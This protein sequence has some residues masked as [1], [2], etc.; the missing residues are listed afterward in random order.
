MRTEDDERPLADIV[1]D[2]DPEIVRQ[3]GA[4]AAML[5]LREQAHPLLEDL[6]ARL[7]AQ[8]G[9][10]CEISLKSPESAK[11]K[12]SRPTLLR[13]RPWFALAHLR[14]FVRFRTRLRSVEDAFRVLDFFRDEF[15]RG[16]VATPVKIDFGKFIAGTRYGWR[17]IACDMR[18]APGML[19]EHYMTYEDQIRLSDIALHGVY[20]RWRNAGAE[21]TLAQTRARARDLDLCLASN[22]AVFRKTAAADPA[23]PESEA[24]G[25]RMMELQDSVDGSSVLLG[26]SLSGHIW[27]WA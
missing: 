18:I 1:N 2:L 12:A 27:S 19:V 21:L 4:L 26:T 24:L 11:Q 17:V 9:L 20:R 25:A 14:D 23:F 7:R 22:D 3:R 15:E 5:A 8:T 13:E 10:A 16:D 6:C